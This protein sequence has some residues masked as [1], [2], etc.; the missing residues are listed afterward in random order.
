[1][2]RKSIQTCEYWW[3]KSGAKSTCSGRGSRPRDRC[4]VHACPGR[5]VDRMRR[6][7]EGE[8]VEDHR[9]VVAA[10]L[11]VDEAVLGVPA[12]ARPRGG[13]GLR[14]V[15]FGPAVERFG[16][17]ADL[18][19]R[20]IVAVE[21]GLAEER[22]G[23][24]Q[25]RVDRSTAR[26][27]R[28]GSAS[29]VEEVVEETSVAGRRRSAPRPCGAAPRKRSVVSTRSRRLLAGDPAALDADRIGGEPE[30]DGG[31]AGERGRRPAVGHQA[32]G[33]G[34]LPEE[35]EGA[36]RDVVE[37]RLLADHDRG[38]RRA[39]RS[40]LASTH[41]AQAKRQDEDRDDSPGPPAAPARGN[42][43]QRPR[44]LTAHA[45]SPAVRSHNAG[46]PD[47]GAATR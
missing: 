43:G 10:P 34:L 45:G 44:E 21:V 27:A 28:S 32:V 4:R 15:P 36:L 47:S 22:A 25:R 42:G 2:P 33:V 19:L 29:H 6:R 14:P 3:P 39:R 31:D 20:G 8:D 26:R 7:A 5:G 13:F 40:R 41:G 38:R 30:T 37:E 24:E 16:E 23:E 1:M 18:A 9:L 11:V 35:K 12:H 46:R 17:L